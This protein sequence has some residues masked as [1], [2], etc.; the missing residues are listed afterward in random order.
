MRAS[1]VL[2][3]HDA[4]VAV[5]HGFF[6]GAVVATLAG[7]LPPVAALLS[8]LWFAYQIFDMWD[9]RRARRR[10]ALGQKRRAS[11]HARH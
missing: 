3:T 10:I 1:E 9:R 5:G 7:W 4:V 6:G 8:I 11:D 2:S